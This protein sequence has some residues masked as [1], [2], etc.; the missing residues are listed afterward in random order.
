MILQQVIDVAEFAFQEKTLAGEIRARDLQRL[1][2]LI[3]PGEEMLRYE[4][5][6]AFSARREA[7]I[8]C[9]IHGSILL[10]C[11]RCLGTFNH[12]VDLCSTLVFVA[13]ESHLPAI[14]DEDESVD[15]VVAEKTLDVL[16]LIE[17]EVILALPL[18]PRHEAGECKE[19]AARQITDA[20]PS[21]F[22]ALSKLKGIS[23]KS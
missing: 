20:K 4:I 21:P 19:S 15:Y 13:D 17:D 7:Q 14:E 5:H 22:A 18:A 8:T 1:Q 16:A 12:V 11:Q 23:K 2:D 9:T 3:V 6:G 10:E